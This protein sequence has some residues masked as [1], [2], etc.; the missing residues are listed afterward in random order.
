M[1]M[2]VIVSLTKPVHGSLALSSFVVESESSRT[3]AISG[4]PANAPRE[5][6]V[7]TITLAPLR[8]LQLSVKLAALAPR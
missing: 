4:N 8:P 6:C 3:M 7:S 2:Q 5:T 1:A